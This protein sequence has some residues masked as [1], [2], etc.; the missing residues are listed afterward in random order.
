[1]SCTSCLS[2]NDIQTS[3]QISVRCTTPYFH[4]NTP[5]VRDIR[6]LNEAGPSRMEPACISII[7]YNALTPFR[8]YSPPLEGIQLMSIAEYE[9]YVCV[10]F[11]AYKTCAA[12]HM[13]A[14]DA[15]SRQYVCF[16]CVK[17]LFNINLI[18][19]KQERKTLKK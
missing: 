13:T 1:M 3:D 6:P 11:F 10:C 7:N 8:V 5:L 16:Y 12:L 19:P 2:N 9:A 15:R 18:T 4:K 14:M 17:K